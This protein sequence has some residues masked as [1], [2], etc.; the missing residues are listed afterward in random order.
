MIRPFVHC[1]SKYLKLKPL[2]RLFAETE[3]SLSL[4][5]PKIGFL[6]KC[7]ISCEIKPTRDAERDDTT[8]MKKSE[9]IIKNELETF[10]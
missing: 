10:R 2:A 4:R 9:V 7:F 3:N 8:I 1:L 5:I 6:A